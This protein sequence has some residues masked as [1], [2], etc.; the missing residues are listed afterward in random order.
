VLVNLFFVSKMKEKNYYSEQLKK[1]H[2]NYFQT[3]AD[4]I[5]LCMKNSIVF[6]G[7]ITFVLVIGMASY[8]DE[9]DPLI[10]NDF[11]LG[12]IW[13]SIIFG[14]RFIF[15]AIG[16]RIASA[17]DNKILS[18][19]K[20]FMLS[21]IAG[22]F[23]LVFSIFWNQYALLVFGIFCMLMSIAEVIQINAIHKEINEEGRTTVM[24]IL[25]LFHNLAMIVFCSVYA[26]LL[27]NHSLRM[28]FIM[29]S[30][31]TIA[32]VI[33]IFLISALSKR[34]HKV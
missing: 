11:G 8:I 7:I 25:D 9:F 16:N 31:Y 34:S 21:A 5:K 2:I 6:M 33:V 18:K 17:V 24:S 4:A 23:L 10:I 26:L 19:N 12:Y 14:I 20:V 32:G 29:V 27:N 22:I 1:E 3:L 30:L 15:I 13:L 28:C